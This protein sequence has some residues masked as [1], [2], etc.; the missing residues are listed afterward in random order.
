MAPRTT[1]SW[2]PRPRSP[3][4]S[5]VGSKARFGP[6][7]RQDQ[8]GTSAPDK[9]DDQPDAAHDERGTEPVPEPSDKGDRRD[10]IVLEPEPAVPGQSLHSKRLVPRLVCVHDDERA[11]GEKGCNDEDSGHCEPTPLL[12]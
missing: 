5:G 1:T 8:I 12:P 7:R 10:V 11:R 6:G 4:P 9:R 2:T 3:P